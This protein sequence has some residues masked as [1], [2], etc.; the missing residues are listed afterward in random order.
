MRNYLSKTHG[1]SLVELLVAITILSMTILISNQAFSFFMQRWNGEL[2]RFNNELAL[3]KTSILVSE[4]LNSIVPYL[5]NLPDGSKGFYFEGNRNGFVAVSQQSIADPETAAVVRLSAVQDKQGLF[6]LLYEEW[7]MQHD[8]LKAHNQFIP[9]SVPIVI[10]SGLKDIRFQYFGESVANNNDLTS[11]DEDSQNR[12]VKKWYDN[13]N[14][15][16]TLRQPLKIEI[17]YQKEELT[18]RSYIELVE[19]LPGMLSELSNS[20][21]GGE[22]ATY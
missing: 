12:N 8:I 9:F 4:T 18:K 22:G 16:D 13:Y 10:Q 17:F 6:T 14:G 20:Q 2:G 1:F 7:P 21:N 11:L 3:I 15:L 19:V 5:V